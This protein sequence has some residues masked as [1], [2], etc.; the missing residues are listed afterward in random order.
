MTISGISHPLKYAPLTAWLG[1]FFEIPDVP[2]SGVFGVV[3]GWSEAS[4]PADLSSWVC[5]PSLLPFFG[6][7]LPSVGS[8]IF[9]NRKH[10]TSNPYRDHLFG[11]WIRALPALLI[12]LNR[13]PDEINDQDEESGLGYTTSLIPPPNFRR[14]SFGIG[15]P[16]VGSHRLIS[17]GKAQRVLTGTM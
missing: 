14:A 1:A 16:K 9:S 11:T 6:F 5:P 15:N 13:G 12:H 2:A 10:V 4:H 3:N 8:L 7:I 17:V